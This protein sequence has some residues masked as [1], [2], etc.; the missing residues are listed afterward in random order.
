M[1]AM[2]S[3]PKAR[4]KLPPSTSTQADKD[5]QPTEAERAYVRA[6]A[7]Q[8]ARAMF[9]AEQRGENTTT[10][11]LVPPPGESLRSD[12]AKGRTSRAAIAKAK[13]EP[14]QVLMLDDDALARLDADELARLARHCWNARQD[15]E[16]LIQAA[17][18]CAVRSDRQHWG[19]RWLF[20]TFVRK[21]G[22][23]RLTKG[24]ALTNKLHNA[25]WLMSQQLFDLSVYAPAL[26]CLKKCDAPSNWHCPSRLDAT[27]AQ[28][29]RSLVFPYRHQSRA[30]DINKAARA[31][32]IG[33]T[34]ADIH[35]LTTDAV[36]KAIERFPDKH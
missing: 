35:V 6:R 27:R 12:G 11:A 23:L 28:C 16:Q 9:E 31:I 20:K 14:Q 10:P 29:A 15:D 19:A 25:I 18:D 8:A 13:Q 24:N 1:G 21:G 2:S 34:K 3:I 5:R 32:I 4:L 7:R 36:R 17:L 30:C 22:R 26:R 33:F